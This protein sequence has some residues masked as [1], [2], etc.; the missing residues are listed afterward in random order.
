MYDIDGNLM[1]IELM[2][3]SPLSDES[4]LHVVKVKQRI[5]NAVI[6][7]KVGCRDAANGEPAQVS[8]PTQPKRRCSRSHD[9]LIYFSSD[10]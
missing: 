3:A 7:N 8:Q 1:Q 9:R 6:K 10:K 5:A 4:Q 2:N